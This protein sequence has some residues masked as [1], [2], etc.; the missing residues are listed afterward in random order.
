MFKCILG[1]F[2]KKKKKPIGIFNN[3]TLELFNKKVSDI[4]N[5]LNN[6]LNINR[7]YKYQ[8]SDVKNFKDFW[9]LKYNT[10]IEGNIYPDVYDLYD[11][12]ESGDKKGKKKKKEIFKKPY[13]KGGFEIEK[14]ELE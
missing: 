10:D 5:F 14:E 13:E 8:K 1:S 2:S 3:Q 4:D 7:E 12:I 11:E 6:Q 9:D